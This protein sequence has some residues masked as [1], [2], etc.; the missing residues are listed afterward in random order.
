MRVRAP[1]PLRILLDI[2][3][4][5]QAHVIRAVYESVRARGYEAEVV[6]RDKDVTLSLLTA[7]SVPFTCL[8]RARPGRLGAARELIEREL[9]FYRVTRRFRPDILLGTS[10]HAAR[11][12][13]LFGGRSV[14]LNEDDAAAVPLFTRIAYPWAHRIVTPDCLR[15]ENWGRRHRTYPGSQKL[16]YLHRDRF[17]PDPDVARSLGLTSPFGLVRLSSLTAHHDVGQRGLDRRSVI[18]LASRL[19]GQVDVLVSTEAPMAAPEGTR[20]LN[21]PPESVHHV[22]AAARFVMSDSQSMTAEAALLGV[23]AVRVNDFVGRLS[24]LAALERRGL[25][26]GFRS[27]EARE[28]IDLVARIATDEEAQAAFKEGQTRYFEDT[29]DPLPWL[30]T[31]IEDLV[32]EA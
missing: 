6:A 32:S 30:I 11:A 23:P 24:S 4:P 9:R 19:H 17:I 7:F 15:H 12:S 10:V 1:G 26:F 8:S 21:A 5:S 27:Q 28:A 3:H 18:E 31:L 2:N 14:I 29:P 13:R 20:L 16:F 25:A 22:M